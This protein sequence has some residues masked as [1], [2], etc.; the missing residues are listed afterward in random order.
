M[1]PKPKLK[2]LWNALDEAAFGP[3]RILNLREML[4]TA[5]EARTKTDV[6]LRARQV[7]KQQGVHPRNAAITASSRRS[8]KLAGTHP[9]LDHRQARTNECASSR[10]EAEKR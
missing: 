8:R 10:V 1:R 2:A 9:R 6:W 4:P 7:R 3:E 5:I